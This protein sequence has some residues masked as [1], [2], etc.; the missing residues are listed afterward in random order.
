ME[1]DADP[2]TL[3]QLIRIAHAGI[4]D[5]RQP[6]EQVL[7]NL[8]RRRGDLREGRLAQRQPQACAAQVL[9]HFGGR[10]RPDPEVCVLQADPAERRRCFHS[11]TLGQDAQECVS[12]PRAHREE[13]PADLFQ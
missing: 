1:H 12:A 7:R 9:R 13:K 6:G 8:R 11:I 2:R 10:H 4:A 5:D 3:Q